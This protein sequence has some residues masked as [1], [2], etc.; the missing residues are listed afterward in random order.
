M[1]EISALNDGMKLRGLTFARGTMYTMAW[2]TSFLPRVVF[3][4]KASRDQGT[5]RRN[6]GTMNHPFSRIC[7]LGPMSK[8]S[9]RSVIIFT[10]CRR[11][12]ISHTAGMESAHKQTEISTKLCTKSGPYILSS[13]FNCGLRASV[14]FG[15][16]WG[17]RSFE[18]NHA[19]WGSR[20]SEWIDAT[21]RCCSPFC[22]RHN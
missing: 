1:E 15:W 8:A 14:G 9:P 11:S 17:S 4:V 21:S 19:G 12:E 2:T 6:E 13:C 22:P 16:P 3:S 10:S 7:H 18:R 5:E 20:S